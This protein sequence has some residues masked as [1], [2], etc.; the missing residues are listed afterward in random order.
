MGWSTLI[1]LSANVYEKNLAPDNEGLVRADVFA[2]LT[3]DGK[4]SN[5]HTTSDFAV[6]LVSQGLIK[7]TLKDTAI[8]LGHGP[9]AGSIMIQNNSGKE[10]TNAYVTLSSKAEISGSKK[11]GWK[12]QHDKSLRLRIGHLKKWQKKAFSITADFTNLEKSIIGNGYF[13]G[14]TFLIGRL[15]V[16]VEADFE[17][18]EINIAEASQTVHLSSDLD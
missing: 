8:K 5:L 12:K 10:L 13:N 3:D 18:N 15:G 2:S 16:N 9:I 6:P 17:S 14:V 7:L 1:T 11:D 4:I